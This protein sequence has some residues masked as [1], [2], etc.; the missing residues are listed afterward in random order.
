MSAIVT[1]TPETRTQ[2]STGSSAMGIMLSMGLPIIVAIWGIAQLGWGA[3]SW[4]GAIVWGVVATAAFTL[5]SIMGKSMGMT[6]MDLLDLLGSVFAPPHS[7]K[8][9]KGQD[10][11]STT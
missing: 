7:S 3:I 2:H 11:S 10:Y 6:K 1:G 4:F 8:A 5:F 9:K